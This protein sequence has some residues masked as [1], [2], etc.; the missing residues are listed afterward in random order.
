MGD[1]SDG[2]EPGTAGYG[3]FAQAD[4]TA[5]Q[6]DRER[7]TI[8]LAWIGARTAVI[9]VFDP[10]IVMSPAWDILL[11]LYVCTQQNKQ[12]SVSSSCLAT[13]APA[14]TA[15]RW[16]DALEARGLVVRRPDVH[17][18]R[19]IFLHLTENGMTRV[20]DALDKSSQSDRKLGIGRLRPGDAD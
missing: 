6:R 16:I 3:I 20:R 9:N 10:A 18:K 2:P 14:S 1:R 15:L 7:L 13:S 4:A 8:A 11:D 17:D 5:D 19:R 12:V